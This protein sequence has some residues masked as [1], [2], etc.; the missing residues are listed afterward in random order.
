MII[1]T[2]LIVVLII[3][4]T[5]SEDQWIRKDENE[6]DQTIDYSFLIHEFYFLF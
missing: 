2:V 3:F 6:R 1:T 4:P 5:I